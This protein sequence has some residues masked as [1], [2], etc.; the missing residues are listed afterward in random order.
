M[1]SG[2]ITLND[3]EGVTVLQALSIAGGLDRAA[4]PQDA[5]I[6]RKALDGD[7]RTEIAV[8]LNKIL[9]GKLS[10]VRMQPEDILF[11]PSSVSKKASV[12]ALEAAVQTAT[13]LAIWRIP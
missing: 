11:V 3:R 1:K 4:K 10:D 6:L 12:R 7:S 5:K 2:G 8:N 13:G 9:E